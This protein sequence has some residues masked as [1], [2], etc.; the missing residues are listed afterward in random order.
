MLKEKIE[1]SKWSNELVKVICDYCGAE[2]EQKL[3][4]RTTCYQ[5]S[6]TDA[7][8]NCRNKKREATSLLKYGTKIPSQ[9]KEVRAKS[10]ETKG[11]CGISIT[12][13]KDRIIEL[14]H[15]PHMS[16]KKIAEVLNLSLTTLQSYMKT[17][18]LDTKGDPLAKKIKTCQEKYGVD[19]FLQ[20]KEGQNKLKQS[21]KE[22]F[23][24][25]NMYDNKEVKQQVLEKS[26]ETCLKKYGAEY[27]LLDSSR[28]EEF[29]EKRKQTRIKNGQIIH[30]N[31]TVTEIAK[32]LGLATSTFYERVQKWGLETAISKDKHTTFIEK[33]LADWLV[34]EDIKHETQFYCDGK[35]VDFKI[36]NLLIET[37]GLYWHSDAV[38]NNNRYHIEK[39][40]IYIKNGYI[41]LFF[42]ED[43]IMNRFDIVKSIILNKLGKS[44]KIFARKCEVKSVPKKIAIDFFNINHLMGKSSGDTFG[45]FLNGELVSAI[46]IRKLSSK[47]YEV[48]RF[49]NKLNF[50]VT[51]G[52]S[53]LLRFVET[54]LSIDSLIT[55][56]DLR[57]GLG[58]YLVDFG[59]KYM[60]SY[61]SFRWTNA[62]ISH[63]R[64]KFKG[65]SGYQFGMYKIWDCG[66][67]KYIK[68]YTIGV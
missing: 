21:F 20:C 8:K 4:S 39:R 17:I 3:S 42:R 63:H 66:Q 57:Y 43:E 48:A 32:E 22:K 56:I 45:L 59:F 54:Q 35:I 27:V 50:G 9:S 16:N 11:G 49:C 19:H 44:K 2:F 62:K 13:Y 58:E 7:C 65:N 31:K 38:I 33:K 47:N 10:S 24:S 53:R 40:E 14:Y 6:P 68:D 26:K 55:F 51:G 5:L 1:L 15:Q 52:F 30:D 18:G 28:K 37:D 61:P 41:S 25:E 67:A 12:E 23:G 29:A 36:D 60:H 46:Q 64:M 34:A